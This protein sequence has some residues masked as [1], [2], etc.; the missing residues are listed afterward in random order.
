MSRTRM[1]RAE[2]IHDLDR[3]DG[4]LLRMF[5]YV[6]PDPHR[7]PAELYHLVVDANLKCAALDAALDRIAETLGIE[8]EEV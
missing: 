3:Q 7:V 1:T 4:S 6:P 8:R 5:A 2:F